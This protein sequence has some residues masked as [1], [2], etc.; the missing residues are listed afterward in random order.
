MYVVHVVD[1][2]MLSASELC[3]NLYT[4]LLHVLFLLRFSMQ[5]ADILCRLEEVRG[6]SVSDICVTTIDEVAEGRRYTVSDELITGLLH[7]VR[8]CL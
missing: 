7:G 8:M 2:C 5:G 3:W 6:H 1:E 4:F